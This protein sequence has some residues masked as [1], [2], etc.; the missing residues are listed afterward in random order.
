MGGARG[1]VAREGLAHAL[2]T[3][4]LSHRGGGLPGGGGRSL[5]ALS[6]VVLRRGGG[7]GA[8]GRR[9]A[10][11]ELAGAVG[12]ASGRG[13]FAALPEGRGGDGRACDRDGGGTEVGIDV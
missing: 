9:G 13:L 1:C 10:V 2:S 3:L 8:S 7:A 11:R 4:H 12:G 5:S 6:G